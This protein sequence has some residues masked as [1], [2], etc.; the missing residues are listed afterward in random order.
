MN[1]S[2][3]MQLYSFFQIISQYRKAD[4]PSQNTSCGQHQDD[5]E[6][7]LIKNFAPWNLVS[8]PGPGSG[9]ECIEC[10][11]HPGEKAHFLLFFFF[12][13][14]FLFDYG[15]IRFLNDHYHRIRI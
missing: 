5:D 2:F 8:N 13:R 10:Q 6:I 7:P 3:F 15:L 11:F 9:A 4:F 12:F 1:G 14:S